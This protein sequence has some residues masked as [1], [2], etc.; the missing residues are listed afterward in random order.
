MHTTWVILLVLLFVLVFGKTK[1]H[2]EAPKFAS[3]MVVREYDDI[4][5]ETLLTPSM[6]ET[7]ARGAVKG[8]L[9]REGRT[10]GSQTGVLD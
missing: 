3:Y 5:S 1:H 4:M 10:H 6:L 8:N 2:M 9:E 7:F